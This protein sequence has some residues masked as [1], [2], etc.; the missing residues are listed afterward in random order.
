MVKHATSLEKTRQEEKSV[1]LSRLSDVVKAPCNTEAFIVTLVGG[2]PAFA[3]S[4][5][6]GTSPF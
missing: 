3:G 4:C 1:A 6:A 2:R 5:P